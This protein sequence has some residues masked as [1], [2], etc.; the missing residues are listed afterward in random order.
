MECP[1]T[2]A[3]AEK[4]RYGQYAGNPNG[5]KYNPRYCAYPVWEKWNDHQ[6]R[7]RA[8]TGPD[9]LYCGHHAKIVEKENMDS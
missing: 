9:K 5:W 3:D 4:M 1:K 7:F 2:R 6:C 8:K